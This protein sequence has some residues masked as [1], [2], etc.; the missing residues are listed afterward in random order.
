MSDFNPNTYR[1]VRIDISVLES[2]AALADVV[3]AQNAAL[4]EVSKILKIRSESEADVANLQHLGDALA[5][6]KEA[7]ERFV[8]LIRSALDLAKSTA[9]IDE[10]A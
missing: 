10:D 3:L 2:V 1:F 6:A 4:L 8:V 9:E 5:P 7:S